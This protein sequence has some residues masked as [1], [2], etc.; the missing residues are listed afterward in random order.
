MRALW[1]AFWHLVA[2]LCQPEPARP[3]D[4]CAAG[5]HQGL[6]SRLLAQYRQDAC[7]ACGKVFDVRG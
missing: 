1:E 2:R 3:A 7:A 5:R 4:E 6:G